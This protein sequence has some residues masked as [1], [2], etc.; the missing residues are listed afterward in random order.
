MAFALKVLRE[1]KKPQALLH[2]GFV[3][4]ALTKGLQEDQQKLDP[5]EVSDGREDHGNSSLIS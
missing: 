3:V 4:S 2:R 5:V 1:M